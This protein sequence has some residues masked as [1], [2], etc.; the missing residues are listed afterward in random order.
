MKLVNLNLSRF[1]R[2]HDLLVSEVKTFVREELKK[3]A[4]QSVVLT[5]NEYRS[6]RDYFTEDSEMVALIFYNQSKEKDRYF[7]NVIKLS[8][9][10]ATRYSYEWF[11][12]MITN[13]TLTRI[14]LAEVSLDTI[15]QTRIWRSPIDRTVLILNEDG[16]FEA[17]AKLP[18][19]PAFES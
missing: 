10:P 15:S 6:L 19:E 18:S 12:Y 1:A 2:K 5:R 16:E 11:R 13:G 9:Q 7:K 17:L 14:K 8:R 3:S 4:A